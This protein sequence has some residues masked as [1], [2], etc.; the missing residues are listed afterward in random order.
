MRKGYELLGQ[1]L[2]KTG[3][4]KESELE[5]ALEKQKILEKPL[6]EILLSEFKINKEVIE[7]SISFQMH[8]KN[9]GITLLKNKIGQLLKYLGIINDKHIEDTLKI[10]KQNK[11]LFGQILIESNLIQPRFLNDIVLAANGNSQAVERLTDK[12]LGEMLVD[13]NYLE[14]QQIQPILE[15]Q[16]IQSGNKK[17]GTLISEKGLLSYSKIER[18]LKIQKKL[19]SLTMVTV[20]SSSVLA[21]CNTPKVSSFSSVENYDESAEVKV[22]SANPAGSVNVYKDGTIAISN[23]PYYKQGNDNTCGQAVMTS[24]LN[25]WGVN[26]NYQ[27]VVNQTNAANL[28][29]DVDKITSYL[30]KKGLYAQDYR[31]ATINFLKD[32]IQ[33]GCP[34]II[35]LDF[36]KLSAEH[37]VLVTGYNEDQQKLI[38]LDPIDGPNVE[39]PY[40]EVLNRWQN[41][42]LKNVGLF[43]DKYTGIAFD[44]TTK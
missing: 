9:S 22:L 28:F 10:Q 37:Y 5:Y 26:I 1:I 11:K 20:L 21:G 36:G 38:L 35:L 31:K 42:S 2:V 30:R 7:Q 40:E 25:Y 16:N 32:R 4:I 17:I 24:L 3:K 29:T 33:K 19:A 44:V 41:V 39:M 8:Q 34:V 23:I 18:V 13:L 15:E 12:K 43:G 6:G 27:T 14:D